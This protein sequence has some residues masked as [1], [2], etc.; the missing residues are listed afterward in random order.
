M[1]ISNLAKA[2]NE[3]NENKT[4]NIIDNAIIFFD[5]HLN[6]S[7]SYYGVINIYCSNIIISDPIFTR[8]QR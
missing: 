4:S 8:L 3:D 7:F 5:S 1:K 6:H 2:R